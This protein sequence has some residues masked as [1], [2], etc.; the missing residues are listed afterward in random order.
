MRDRLVYELGKA[1][2]VK[3]HFPCVLAHKLPLSGFGNR[4]AKFVPAYTLGLQFEAR[5]TLEI[6][7]RDP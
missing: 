4:K 6:V 5:R 2:Q 7:G 3:P 1:G